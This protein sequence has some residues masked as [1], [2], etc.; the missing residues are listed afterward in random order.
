M[1]YDVII[2]DCDGVMFDTRW[3][4][5]LYYNH[6]LAHFNLPEM[7]DE[8]FEYSHSH[9]AADAVRYLCEPHNIPDEDVLDYLR[10]V[11]YA[12]Y[13]K[14]MTINPELKPLIDKIRPPCRTAVA[15]NRSD[16]M[17]KVVDMFTLAPYFDKIM[18]AL[19]VKY[20]KPDPAMILDIISHFHVEKDR[21]LY[22]GD[23]KVDE[24]ASMRGEISF[25]AFQDQSLQA[26]YH[27]NA[28]SQLE[29]I[30]L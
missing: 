3:V 26:D 20:P 8:Q 1:K 30:I 16:T 2:F 7:T 10:N 27:I 5:R 24:Q 6:M 9:S 23:T 4:N 12:E 15:T 19:D 17:P 18:T 28:L 21:V 29:A 11:N 22:I 13:I 25:V 14:H